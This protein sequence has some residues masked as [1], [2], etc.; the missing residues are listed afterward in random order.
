MKHAKRRLLWLTFAAS[1]A[2]V[3]DQQVTFMMPAQSS[4]TNDYAFARI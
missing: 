1:V 3:I 2:A 4:P